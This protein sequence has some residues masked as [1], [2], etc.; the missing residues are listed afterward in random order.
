[1]MGGAPKCCLPVTEALRQPEERLPALQQRCFVKLMPELSWSGVQSLTPKIVC[2]LI[3]S[4][5]FPLLPTF[6]DIVPSDYRGT[7][8]SSPLLRHRGHIN[9]LIEME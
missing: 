8:L 1:M 9:R 6:N 2:S 7:A 4:H 5:V 3:S